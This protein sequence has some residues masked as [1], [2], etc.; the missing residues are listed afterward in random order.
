MH[1]LFLSAVCAVRIIPGPMAI[2]ELQVKGGNLK[3]LVKQFGLC[4]VQSA[5]LFVRPLEG[6]KMDV[7]A[8]TEDVTAEVNRDDHGG[9]SISE[10]AC[11]GNPTPTHWALKLVLVCEDNW[12]TL[13]DTSVVVEKGLDGPHWSAYWPWIQK[14]TLMKAVQIGNSIDLPIATRN[15]LVL[16][17]Q[18]F[19]A[20]FPKYETYNVK[21][22]NCQNFVLDFSKFLFPLDVCKS[23]ELLKQDSDANEKAVAKTAG[24]GVARGGIL[25]VNIYNFCTNKKVDKQKKLKKYDFLIEGVEQSF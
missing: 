11:S 16:I 13:V 21:N 4:T 19:V 6:V 25:V 9:T 2:L 14:E 3:S 22:D 20:A 10:K 1:F 18:E 23:L 5:T 17:Y 15:N 12:G 7:E 24:K 8:W